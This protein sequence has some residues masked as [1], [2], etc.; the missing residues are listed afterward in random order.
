MAVGG[1]RAAGV[2][3][4]VVVGALEGLAFQ[5]VWKPWQAALSALV[6]TAPHLEDNGVRYLSPDQQPAPEALVAAVDDGQCGTRRL[7]PK[8]GGVT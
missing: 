2:E 6:P 8:S 4:A 7:V 5:G 3:V 1:A